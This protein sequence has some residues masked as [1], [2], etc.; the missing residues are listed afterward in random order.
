MPSDTDLPFTFRR[1][2]FPVRPCFA[3]SINKSQGQTFKAIGI[4]LT[5]PCF[6]HGM[7]YVAVSRTG[8]SNNINILASRRK[9]RNVV[10]PEVL[11]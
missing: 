3:M 2:Q 6:S 1:L 7:F 11:H 9:T 5:N 10:Y 4:D 8:T